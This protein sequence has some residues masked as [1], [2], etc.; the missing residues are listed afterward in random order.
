MFPG[1][2]KAVETIGQKIDEIIKAID[3][4]TAAIEADTAYRKSREQKFDATLDALGRAGER[5]G[6][7]RADVFPGE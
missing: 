5:I 4:H 6:N 7:T 1:L 2:D 3:R